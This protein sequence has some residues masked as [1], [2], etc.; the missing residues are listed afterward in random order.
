[1]T[2]KVV[3]EL[4]IKSYER[5]MY[6]SQIWNLTIAKN[7]NVNQRKSKNHEEYNFS[8]E[9]IKEIEKCAQNSSRSP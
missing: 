3:H 9:E 6:F 7:T 8:L 5:F 4:L 2:S 1:M